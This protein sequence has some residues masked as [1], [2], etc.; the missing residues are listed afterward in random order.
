MELYNQTKLRIKMINLIRYS[1][2][3]IIPF[4]YYHGWTNAAKSKDNNQL[5]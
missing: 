4:K 5:I 1:S 2:K 3:G